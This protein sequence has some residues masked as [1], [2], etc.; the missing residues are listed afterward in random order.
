M[1]SFYVGAPYQMSLPKV[2]TGVAGG[3]ITPANIA[4]H[5][6]A[7]RDID[8]KY[9]HLRNRLLDPQLYLAELNAASCRKTC[10]NL[11]SYGWFPLTEALPFDS[12]TTTQQEWSATVKAKIETIWTGRTPATAEEIEIAVRLCVEAQV[13]LGVE[14]IILPSPL[15]QDPTS[16]YA[17]ELEWLE[18][19]EKIA[20]I[21]APHLQTLATVAISDVALRGTDAWSNRLLD[22]ILDQLTSRGLSGAYIV[23]VMASEEAYY[24]THPRTVGGL[25]RVCNGLRAGGA[26]RV[27]VNFAG[28]AGLMCLA[29]GADTWASGWYRSQRRMRLS[30]YEGE[31]GRVFPA[32]YSHPLGGEF[33]M[34]HDLDRVVAAGFLPRVH[35]S[36]PTSSG[37]MRALSTGQK[38]DNVAAW[39][40]TSGN[41][42]ASTE[43]FLLASA[44]ETAGLASLSEVEA[45]DKVKGWLEVAYR[46]SSDLQAAGPFNARTALKHQHGWLSAFNEFATNRY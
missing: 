11:A 6:I 44:R 10:S 13:A 4:H 9:P 31:G 15:T 30:D 12:G 8:K 24:Y 14:A 2:V 38:V 5:V 16:T 42:T 39:R 41:R 19:G 21:L 45:I 43:H 1:K 32:F 7:R 17:V 23:P 33:H 37:L 27:V 46:I 35:D 22:V 36:T 20:A 28:T 3:I 26:R 34:E 40:H 25:L 29:A 18:R